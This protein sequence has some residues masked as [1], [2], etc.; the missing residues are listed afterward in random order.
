MRLSVTIC[1]AAGWLWAGLAVL[2]A[3]AVLVRLEGAA[4]SHSV[5][6]ILGA[7][8]LP[9]LIAY[10]L[11]GVGRSRGRAVLAAGLTLILLLLAVVFLV[12]ML[13]DIPALPREEPAVF[14]GLV[15]MVAAQLGIA[16]AVVLALLRGGGVTGRSGPE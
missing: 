1:R 10:A 14:A 9:A 15:V 6:P 3:A 2:G 12:A 4:G 5:G 13:R 7:A 8:G 16:A 11:L